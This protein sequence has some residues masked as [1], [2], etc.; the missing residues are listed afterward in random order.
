MENQKIIELEE[1]IKIL[2]KRLNEIT[3]NIN[4]VDEAKEITIN[5]PIG[6]VRVRSNQGKMNFQNCPIG[7]VL[8]GDIDEAE[9]RLDELESRLDDIKSSIDEVES[10]IDELEDKR[11]E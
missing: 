1:K 5:G 10:S 7:S 9:E 3:I 4:E 6:E 8:D 11:P 2:E